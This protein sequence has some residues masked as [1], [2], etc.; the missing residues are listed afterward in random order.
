MNSGFK[1][2]VNM[3]IVAIMLTAIVFSITGLSVLDLGRAVSQSTHVAAE[4]MQTQVELESVMNIALWRLNTG[5]D[6]LGTFSIGDHSSAYDTSSK[7]LSITTTV[8][9]QLDGFII[10]L[11]EDSHFMRAVAASDWINYNDKTVNEDPTHKVRDHIGFLPQL[12]YQYFIDHADTVFYQSWRNYEDEDLVEGMNI[13]HCSYIDVQNINKANT[14][15]IFTGVGID[16]DDNIQ[17]SA[18]VIEGRPLPAMIFTNIYS[19]VH[20]DQDRGETIRVEGPIYS[21]GYVRIHEATLSGPVV[22]DRVR[23]CQNVDMI[24]DQYPQY[25]SWPMGFGN[26]AD[27]DWPKQIAKWEHL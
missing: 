26:Y 3:Y 5:G 27:Y 18:P 24:D 13:F 12:D 11:S 20:F 25:Y 17:L 2:Q 16:L 21:V 7:T 9:E 14:T 10:D 15:L 22:A 4:T 8:H 6:S 1:E 23:F 19:D